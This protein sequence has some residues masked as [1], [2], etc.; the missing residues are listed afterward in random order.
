[1]I[2][3]LT[4]LFIGIGVVAAQIRSV[5]GT[6]TGAEDGLPVVGASVLVKGTSMGTITDI[7]GN[8]QLSNVPNSAKTLQISYIGMKTIEVAITSHVNVTLESDSKIIDEVVVVAY[9]T[10]KKESL[11]G[12]Q[13]NVGARELEKRPLTNVTSAL[14]ATAPGVQS[15][16]STGQPG[17]S[18]SLMIRGFGSI[19]A[20]SS[21]LYVVDGAIFNGSLSDIA[22]SDV[23]SIS[24]LKDAASTSLY[25]SSA[26]NGVVLITTKSGATANANKPSITLTINQGFTQKGL[27]DY[28]TVNAMQ[29]YP[30]RWQ[31]W[32]N[33]Y[34]QDGETPDQAAYWANYDVLQDL[35]YQPYAGI[36]SQLGYNGS[37][38]LWEA[39]QANGK[40]LSTIPKIVMEDGTL[41]PEITGLL[42]ADDLDWE[43]ALF[44]T[45]YRQEYSLS[46]SYNNDKVESFY[47]LSYLNEDGYRKA[48]SFERFA[49]RANVSYNATNWLRLGTNISFSKKHNEAPKTASGSYGSNSFNFYRGIAPIYPIHMHNADG[50][51]V[52]DETGNKVFDH[53]STR[54]YAGRF[55]PVEEALLDKA[56]YD[57]DAVNTRSFLEFNIVKGLKFRTNLSYDLYRAITKTRYNNV[58]GDQPAGLLFIEDARM[59]SITFNQLLTYSK[60]FDKHNFDVLLGHENY[61]YKYYNS[62]MSKTGMGIL[63][64]DEMPNFV[65][66]D[67]ISSGTT[68]YKKEGYFGR[69]NYD[70]DSK[71]H[72]SLSYRRDGTSRLAPANRWGNFWSFGLGWNI[73]RESFFKADWVDYL[74]LR[75]SIG[76]TGNDAIGSYYAYQTLYSFGNNNNDKLG[77]RF[78]SLGTP[79][80]KWETQT[81]SDVAVEFSVFNK[82]RGT[83]ELFN[84]ASK[85]LLFPYPL[86]ASTGLGERN[87]NLGKVRN[88]GLEFDLTYNIMQTRDFAWDITLNGT[89]LKN[90]IVT[91]PEDNRENGIETGIYKYL[92]GKSIYD[93]YLRQWVG[94]DPKDGRAM[95]VFDAENYDA[96]F[97]MGTE[98]VEAT[99][100]KNSQYAKKDYSGSAIPKLYGGFGTN[101]TYKGFDF[102]VLF[103]YQLGGKTYDSA[104]QGLMGRSLKGGRTAHVDMLK[105]WRKEGQVTD[106]PA[107]YYDGLGDYDAS[108]S[109]R[110]LISSDALMLKT[111]S[112]GY[113]LPNAWTKSLGMKDIR[114]SV[115]GENLFLA[116]ARKGMNPFNSFGGQTGSAF[117]EFARTFTGSVSIKF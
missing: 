94:V 66:M 78:G 60:S 46:G 101:L 11:V 86:P 29:I 4:Y 3:L 43:K 62:E 58:M 75:A 93:F 99:L 16:T 91:L 68:N 63:G 38:K 24:V 64:I 8:F 27:A 72:A 39:V 113:T 115:A 20:S 109:N 83:V 44:R 97:A 23:Q 30:L 14:A 6:V 88:Y 41:N 5:S 13:A 107:L 106:V 1:M 76:Q 65:A 42:W 71:Y 2:L 53:S 100:T 96:K 105:A 28:E 25:G 112:L 19:N 90:K 52:L 12:A 114:F 7:D 69:L 55:N 77:V 103:S 35:K 56:Y 104:Y 102:N 111:V 26:G 31:Q 40:Y 116:S 36:T 15:L 18:T 61:A 51:Y 45:G 9:G 37:T 70:Y 59:T 54:P 87:M 34:I 82:L 32:Y 85:D 17:S 21:P 67:G 80:L 110:F 73:A 48:T 117:Y 33:S 92:E 10:A 84:K 95:Y 98:G 22:P 50:T 81:S 79:E 47:S 89:M 57:A 74:K 49:G 108:T